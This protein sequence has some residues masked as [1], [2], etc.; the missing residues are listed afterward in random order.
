MKNLFILITL[1]LL[2]NG[3]TQTH[4]AIYS[5]KIE[6]NPI[7][8]ST[9]QKD[10]IGPLAEENE[11]YLYFN[12]ENSYYTSLNVENGIK[13]M[14]DAMGGTYYPIKYN[15]KT[16]TLLF[17]TEFDKMYVVKDTNIP[18]WTITN[19]T[20]EIAGYTC[21][22]ATGLYKDVTKPDK[23]FPVE[24]WFSP[25]LPYPIGPNNF[26]NLPGML[27]YGVFNNYQIYKLEKIKFN[28]NSVDIDAII[29]EGEEINNEQY[30]AFLKQLLG[31]K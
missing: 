24:A 2:T 18:I 5:F 8:G 26:G 9:Q 7:T 15:Y 1:L 30:T 22:K 23:F 3:Y 6:A 11:Y 12:K 4:K 17:N 10:E 27:I 31:S 14:S 29:F 19:E 16:R 28:D 25:E 20:K 21:I 13:D